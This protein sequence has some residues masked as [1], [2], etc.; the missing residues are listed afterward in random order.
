MIARNVTVAGRR[1]SLRMEPEMWDALQEAAA[2]EGQTLHDFCTA[3]AKRRGAFSMTAAI[4][5]H[6]LGYFRDAATEAGHRNAG[7]GKLAAKS[8]K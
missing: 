6:L 7:H 2:R 4:R 1:T 5:V 8:R 3:V